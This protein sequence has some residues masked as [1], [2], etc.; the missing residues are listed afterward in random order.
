ME[1]RK[2]DN[3]GEIT[4]RDLYP[5]LNEEQLKQAEENLERYIALQLRVY[6]R[7]LAD[8]EVYA[9]FKVLTSAKEGSTIDPKRSNPP[10][11]LNTPSET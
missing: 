4:A 2:H 7:I 3:V 8:P 6:D 5:H 11:Q 1:N 10:S 9:G